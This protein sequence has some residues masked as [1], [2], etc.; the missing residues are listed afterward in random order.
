MRAEP[1]LR[2]QDSK[3][4]GERQK[5][6]APRI[7]DLAGAR[8]GHLGFHLQGLQAECLGEITP[9]LRIPKE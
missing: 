9:N 3:A 7:Q 4:Q 8:A 2:E 6:W 1:A 5:D